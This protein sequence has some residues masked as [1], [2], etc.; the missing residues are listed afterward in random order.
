MARLESCKPGRLLTAWLHT[1]IAIFRM[2]WSCWGLWRSG[3][4]PCGSQSPR[5]WAD[6]QRRGRTQFTRATLLIYSYLDNDWGPKEP[7]ARLELP[8]RPATMGACRH[9]EFLQSRDDLASANGIRVHYWTRWTI[10][11]LIDSVMSHHINT[12]ALRID[13]NRTKANS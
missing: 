12:S 9:T 10:C 4:N 5:E 7:L 1:D 11:L 8:V 2:Q 6:L 3:Y 13:A